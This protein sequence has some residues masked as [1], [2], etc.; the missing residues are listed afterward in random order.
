MAW[1]GEQGEPMLDSQRHHQVTKSFDPVLGE[2]AGAPCTWMQPDFPWLAPPLPSLPYK[3]ACM[4]YKGDTNGRIRTSE[5]R[6]FHHWQHGSNVKY[7]FLWDLHGKDGSVTKVIMWGLHFLIVAFKNE[8]FSRE[9]VF[10]APSYLLYSPVF[11]WGVKTG[12][13]LLY[14]PC[15]F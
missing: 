5:C 12:L 2:R 6:Q 14:I 10:S 7:I 11:S 8:C 4:C 1:L 13:I 9:R 3:W 15:R